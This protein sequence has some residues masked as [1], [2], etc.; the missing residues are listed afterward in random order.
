[1]E[2]PII[3]EKKFN[4]IKSEIHTYI[5]KEDSQIPPISLFNDL[6]QEFEKIKSKYQELED[7][8]NLLH[9]EHNYLWCKSFQ[10]LN[11]DP[12]KSLDI[13]IKALSKLLDRNNLRQYQPNTF[14]KMLRTYEVAF[15]KISKKNE[16]IKDGS[17]KNNFICFLNAYITKKSFLIIPNKLEDIVKIL[18]K[19]FIIGFYENKIQTYII[20]NSNLNEFETIE[21]EINSILKIFKEIPSEQSYSI[22]LCY[23]TLYKLIKKE[24]HFL[25]RYSF[26]EKSD[27]KKCL[28]QDKIDLITDKLIDYS[29][30]IVIYVNKFYKSLSPEIQSD[31]NNK[32]MVVLS[33]VDKLTARYYKE[34]YSNKDIFKAWKIIDEIK[35][36]LVMKAFKE[37]IPLSDNLL[38]YYAEEWSLLYV[39]AKICLLKE[40]VD[41]RSSSLGQ[42]W[43]KD[44]FSEIIESLSIA[45]RLFR[46][47]MTDK[48]D[49]TLKIMTSS[50]SGGFSEYFVHELCQEFFDFSIVDDKTPIEFKNFLECVKLSRKKE[51]IVLKDFIEPGQPDIDIHIKNK[52]AIFLKNSKIESDEIKGIWSEIALCQK[53]GI[54]KIFY[55]I[56]FIKNIE[57]IDQIRRAFEK[58][59]REYT[60]VSIEIHDIKDLVNALLQE[61]KRSGKSKLNFSQLDLYRVLDY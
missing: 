58:I 2:N 38:K 32:S 50:F 10:Y 23:T 47:E 3:I 46:Y 61:L 41:K 5:L 22:Y 20:S 16:P 15:I 53:N 6:D 51:D 31:E 14:D 24:L 56:N 7:Q 44:M 36:L 54:K 52:C 37:N 35:Q 48:K 57:R 45:Q 11:S 19:I 29:N 26:F 27:S 25:V 49:Y 1:M 18:S 40:E 28:A 17:I 8:I 39:F 59:K 9:V 42:E 34:T 55:C 43:E 33:E 13:I 30:N 4:E 12:T 21:N 60:N